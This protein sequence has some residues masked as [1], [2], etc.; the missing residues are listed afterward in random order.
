M[1]DIVGGGIPGVDLDDS[2]LR[3]RY[4]RLDR[5][6]DEV[7]ANLSLLLNATLRSTLGPHAFACFR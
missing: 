3:E 2:H 4:N 7:L 5:V 1:F 6:R